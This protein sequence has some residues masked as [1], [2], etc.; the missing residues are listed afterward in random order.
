MLGCQMS[1]EGNVLVW[2][3]Q[4]DHICTSHHILK[5]LHHRNTNLLPQH[6]SSPHYCGKIWPSEMSLLFSFHPFLLLCIH[7]LP[8][9]NLRFLLIC[10]RCHCAA[11]C[12]LTVKL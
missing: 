11:G 10:C 4:N 3:E 6:Y 12:F 8:A 2:Q 5:K 7:F 1:T 9:F